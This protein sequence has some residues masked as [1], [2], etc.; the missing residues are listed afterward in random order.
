MRHGHMIIPVEA[1]YSHQYPRIESHFASDILLLR[2]EETFVRKNHAHN[3][4]FQGKDLPE[5]QISPY[6]HFLM[7]Q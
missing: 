6:F 1:I 5:T 3:K 4:L 2:T 7:L